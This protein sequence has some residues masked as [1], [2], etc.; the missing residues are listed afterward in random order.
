MPSP[1]FTRW[2]VSARTNGSSTCVEAATDG[3]LVAVQNSTLRHPAGPIFQGAVEGKARLEPGYRH[4]RRRAD[5]AGGVS[6]LDENRFIEFSGGTRSYYEMRRRIRDYYRGHF[7]LAPQVA[8]LENLN[9]G[10][11]YVSPL[12]FEPKAALQVLQELFDWKAGLALRDA[13]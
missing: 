13:G 1:R 2:R 11:C 10:A 7:Q 5:R 6:A 9:P 4:A 12:C 3:V 8:A